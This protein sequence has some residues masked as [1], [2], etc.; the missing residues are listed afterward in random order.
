MLRTNDNCLLGMLKHELA[1]SRETDE[2]NL[3]IQDI[4]PIIKDH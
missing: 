4:Y 1:S 2:I 3:K